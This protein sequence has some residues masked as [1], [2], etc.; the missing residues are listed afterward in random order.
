MLT[1]TYMYTRQQ[2]SIKTIVWNL[3]S[4]RV[5]WVYFWGDNVKVNSIGK[6]EVALYSF[7]VQLLF[8]TLFIKN[9]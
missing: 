1:Y 6:S 5:S 3:S 4:L 8:Y 9:L 7:Y 2:I